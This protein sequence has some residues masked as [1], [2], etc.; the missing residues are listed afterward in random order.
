M[1]ADVEIIIY[2][3]PNPILKNSV[4]RFIHALIGILKRY[5]DFFWFS[6]LVS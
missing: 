6:D 3:L 1:K 2:F 4:E 5:I